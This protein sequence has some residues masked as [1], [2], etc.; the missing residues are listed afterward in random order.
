MDSR[1]WV[2]LVGAGALALGGVVFILPR[3]W[4]GQEVEVERA[5]S[6]LLPFSL[7]VKRGLTRST[8]AGCLAV[9]FAYLSV[10]GLSVAEALRG[11]APQGVAFWAL[12]GL[13]L[14]GLALLFL[15]IP[16]IILFNRPT[17]AVAPAYRADRGAIPMW[18]RA[19]QL[20]RSVRRSKG[21]RQPES[22]DHASVALD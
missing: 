10:L 8:A 1:D 12:S 11:S 7:A 15:F 3:H 2:V 9:F 19:R 5:F 22:G 13:G 20:R 21:L 14:I 4:R 18:R 17:F 6:G 16:A